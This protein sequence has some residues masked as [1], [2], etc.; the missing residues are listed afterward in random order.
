MRARFQA[1]TL[2]PLEPLDLPEGAEVLLTVEELLPAAPWRDL[3]SFHCA[4]LEPLSATFAWTVPGPDSGAPPVRRCRILGESG[5]LADLPVPSGCLHLEHAVALPAHAEARRQE[6]SL[7][8]VEPS[9]LAHAVDTVPIRLP[10]VHVVLRDEVGGPPAD[11]GREGSWGRLEDGSWTDSP[12]G[13]YAN[14]ADFSLT[15]PLISLGPLEGTTL[16][17]EERHNIEEFSD[18][19]FLEVQGEDGP[20]ERVARYTGISASWQRQHLDLSAWDGTR[21]RLRFRM[22]SDRSVTRDGFYF[23]NLLLAGRRLR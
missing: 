7:H 12:V 15:S 1:G 18:W 20:W 8:F 19:C 17:F 10:G 14:S 3:A 23:R 13:D 5:V 22:V 11:W 4:R 9:G 16:D 21:I 6:F 2:V